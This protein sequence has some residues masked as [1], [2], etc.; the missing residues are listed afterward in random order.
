M[1]ENLKR[2]IRYQ[3]GSVAFKMAVFYGLSKYAQNELKK[4]GY[5]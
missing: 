2:V 1:D 5:L 3:I 4:K